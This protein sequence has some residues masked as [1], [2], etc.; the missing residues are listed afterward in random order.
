MRELRQMSDG[1]Y[2]DGEGSRRPTLGVD[3]FAAPGSGRHSGFNSRFDSAQSR[4]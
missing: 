2:G 4:R 1:E 3:Y